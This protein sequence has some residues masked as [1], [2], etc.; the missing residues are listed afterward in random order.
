[1]QS[2]QELVKKSMEG[3]TQ[4]FEKLVLQYQNK[5]YALSFRHMGNEDDA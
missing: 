1:M 3:D 2:E 4:A 5:V